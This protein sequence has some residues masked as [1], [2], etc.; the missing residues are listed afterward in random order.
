MV[1]DG[2]RKTAGLRRLVRRTVLGGGLSFAFLVGGALALDTIFPP[3]LSRLSDLAQDVVDRDGIILRSYPADDGRWRFLARSA[4]SPTYLRFLRAYEDKRFDHHFGVDPLALLRASVQIV[5]HGRVVSGGSTLT[6][7]VARLLEPRPRNLTSKLVEMFRAFQLEAR[8]SKLEILNIYLTLAPFGGNLEGVVSASRFYF[9]KSPEHLTVSEAALLVALPQSPTARRTD[10]HPLAARAARARVLDRLVAAG[11][12]SPHSARD[13]AEDSVPTERLAQPFSAPHLADEARRETASSR[14]TGHPI[15]TTIDGQLQQGVERVLSNAIRTL[16]KQFSVAALVIEHSNS[17]VV[18]EIRALV[19]SPDIFDRHRSGAIDMTRAIRSPGSTLKPLIY[20]QSFAARQTHPMT[21]IT[22]RL[23]SFAGYQPG[24][25]DNRVRGDVTLAQALQLSLNIP[26]VAVLER[27][28]PNHFVGTLAQSGVQLA[29]QPGVPPGLPIALGGAGISLRELVLAYSSLARDG[30]VAPLTFSGQSRVPSPLP[31]HF[32]S[33]E[34]AR[35]VAKILRDA[36]P[37]KARIAADH[38]A[39]SSILAFKTGTSYGFRDLWAIGYD[40]RY[41]IGVWIG[42]PD[43]GFGE[44][45]TGRDFAAP[46]LFTIADLLPTQ[47]VAEQPGGDLTGFLAN[48]PPPALRRFDAEVSLSPL[49][50]ANELAIDFP[51]DGATIEAPDDTGVLP[52][53]PMAARGGKLPLSW[54]VNGEQ[55]ESPPFKRKAHYK[56]VG[57]GQ[58][59]I[60]V[61]DSDGAASKSIIWIE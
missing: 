59:R 19:G 39:G 18:S 37:P 25:F 30:I 20:A 5:Q 28:G 6:M 54:F 41:T 38:A 32:V 13:A 47:E 4:V 21:I 3:D 34:A 29:L 46:L 40:R 23:R 55:V 26:A 33:S 60:S 16:P 27:L 49:P 14:I 56:P 11:V 48:T 58:H 1:S 53:I 15:R 9:G 36:P 8:L 57:R 17:S 24:N 61:I 31:R 44:R 10:R 52:V 2:E 22:D 42:R 12:L 7:Q 43:G 50:N 45:R 51:R 35:A